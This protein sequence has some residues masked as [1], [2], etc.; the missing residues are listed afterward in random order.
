M[1]NELSMESYLCGVVPSEMP[2]SYELEALKAQAVCARSYARRQME[3]YGYPEYEA[4]VN[5]STDFQ[6]YNN[7][8]P[9]ERSSR[10]C[11]RRKGKL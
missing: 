2:A 10:R 11:V 9:Q 3:S 8:Q 7:S 4:H 1:I 6:V 5:D